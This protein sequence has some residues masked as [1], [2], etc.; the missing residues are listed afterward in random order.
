MDGL[1]V[2]LGIP[3]ALAKFI[4]RA[5]HVGAPV[6]HFVGLDIQAARGI[7]LEQAPTIRRPVIGFV[8]DAAIAVELIVGMPALAA[9]VLGNRPSKPEGTTCC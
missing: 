8:D 7:D 4:E 6:P 2:I 5:V 9:F 3:D 1:E